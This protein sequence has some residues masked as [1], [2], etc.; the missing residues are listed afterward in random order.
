MRARE[1]LKEDADNLQPTHKSAIDDM[2]SIPNMDAYYEFYRF[3]NLTAGEPEGK[4][5][6]TGKLRDTPVA[7]PYTDHDLE[8]IKRAAKKMGKTITQLTPNG[9]NELDG[10]NKNSPVAKIKKNRYGV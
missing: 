2:I 3:M 6:P 4:I 8:M 5:T 10:T 1:F 7:L 9:S